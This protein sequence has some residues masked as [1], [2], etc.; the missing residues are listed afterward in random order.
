MPVGAALP[1][2]QRWQIVAYLR[3]LNTTRRADHGVT[4]MQSPLQATGCDLRAVVDL[5]LCMVFIR[6]RFRAGTGCTYRIGFDAAGRLD[7]RSAVS[8]YTL[9][10][11][12]SRPI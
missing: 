9:R 2:Q 12:F 6:M 3:S 7:R 4:A 11:S 5:Q 1:E 10:R 8:R